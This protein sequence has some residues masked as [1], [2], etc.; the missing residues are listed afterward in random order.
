MHIYAG[1]KKETSTI[2]RLAVCI[3]RDHR[4]ASARMQR[5]ELAVAKLSREKRSSR[6]TEVELYF[7]EGLGRTKF[8]H[9]I[10]AGRLMHG[11]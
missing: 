2:Q 1:G 6:E 7:S 4:T 9:T 5:K 3:K 11:I 8:S 10:T